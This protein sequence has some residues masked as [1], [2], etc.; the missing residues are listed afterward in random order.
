MRSLKHI[1]QMNAR[2]VISY[3]NSQALNMFPEVRVYQKR[4]KLDMFPEVYLNR[5]A[6]NMFLEAHLNR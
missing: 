3:L 1:E 2:Y 6:F 5:Q 4:Q